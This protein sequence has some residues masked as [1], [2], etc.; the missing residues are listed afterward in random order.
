MRR[1]L[2]S[3]ILVLNCSLSAAAQNGTFV[4]FDHPNS[5]QYDTMPGGINRSGIIVGTYFREG[6]PTTYSF[7]R[8]ANGTFLSIGFPGA[9]E[10]GLWGINDAADL[11]GYYN[12][13]TP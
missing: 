5:F 13:F 9:F 4:P 7:E 2:I 11:A 3:I 1:L 12:V 10:T 6:D 8:L